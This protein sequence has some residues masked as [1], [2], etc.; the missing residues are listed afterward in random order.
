MN[1]YSIF[2][3]SLEPDEEGWRAFC[4]PLNISPLP[5]GAKP[6]KKHVSIS[7]KFWR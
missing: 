1:T 7:T 5:H 6:K 4:P 2:N 3:V